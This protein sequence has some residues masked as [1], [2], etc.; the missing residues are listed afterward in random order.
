ML[1][2]SVEDKIMK[3]SKQTFVVCTFCTFCWTIYFICWTVPDK[4]VG[5]FCR[6]ICWTILSTNLLDNL[7]DKHKKHSEFVGQFSEFVLLLDKST[8]FVLFVFLF[9]NSDV[10]VGQF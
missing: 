8:K 10:F 2:N 3:K 4:F 5:Q 6:Q 7:L 1:D 9:D